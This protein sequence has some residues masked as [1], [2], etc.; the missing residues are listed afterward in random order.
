MILNSS[1]TSVTLQQNAYINLLT[2]NH[3]TI[4]IYAVYT[5]GLGNNSLIPTLVLLDITTRISGEY[6]INI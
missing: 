3:V 6:S 2:F 4:I 5:H 1:L